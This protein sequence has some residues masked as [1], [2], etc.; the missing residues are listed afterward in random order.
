M[1]ISILLVA[2]LSA[3]SASLMV[4]HP[5]K[6]RNKIDPAKGEI[7]SSMANF[8]HFPYGHSIIGRVWHE[9]GNENGCKEFETEIT[10]EGDPDTSPS[11]IVI[12]ERG[13]CSFVKKVR[14]IEHAG[15]SLAIIIDNKNEIVEKVIMVD[16]GTGVGIKIPS[17]LIGKKDGKKIRKFYFI[18]FFS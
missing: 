2:L 9:K 3:V 14:N 1:K 7:D 5:S 6:L 11:P 10:G 17:L 18:Y 13:D 4:Y 16:D 12:V 8:G 15:G